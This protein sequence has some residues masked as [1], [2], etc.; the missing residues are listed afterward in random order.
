MVIRV[1]PKKRFY[2]ERKCGGSKRKLIG[3][4]N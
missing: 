2:K 1:H 4:Q 3:R